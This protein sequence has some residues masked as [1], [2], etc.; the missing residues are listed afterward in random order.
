MTGAEALKK[1]KEL[2]L[3][4]VDFKFL[5][6]VG[7][8][9]HFSAPLSAIDESVFEKGMGFDGSS[10]RGWCEIH[11]SDMVAVPDPLTFKIDPF[12]KV[13][14]ASFICDIAENEYITGQDFIIDGG[15][16]AV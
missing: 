7:L 11:K 16:S 10:V 9:Q 5:D 14:T 3:H 12:V 8:W 13:P 4:M 2:G 6:F 15:Y 1:A